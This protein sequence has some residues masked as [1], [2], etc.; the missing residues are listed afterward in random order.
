MPFELSRFATDA[1]ANNP[2]VQ[3]G[4]VGL[5]ALVRSEPF[6]HL[7]NAALD[8]TSLGLPEKTFIKAMTGGDRVTPGGIELSNDQL[9]RL[10]QAYTDQKDPS[11]RPV[12]MEFDPSREEFAGMS[13]EEL[14]R[15][16]QFYNENF[17]KYDN[18]AL[19][20]FNSPYVSTY[21]NTPGTSGY[22]RDL[23]MT[24][25]GLSMTNTPDGM[26][27]QDTWDID[28]ASEVAK[29]TSTGINERDKDRLDL[30]QD[31]KEGGNVPSLIANAARALNT[32]EPIEIDQTVP[33]NTWNSITPR[34]V[35]FEERVAGNQGAALQTLNNLYS[36]LFKRQ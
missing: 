8:R 19:A 31:L 25:G 27:I 12:V 1:I 7:R 14:E 10:K 33:A 11:R 16:R 13:P 28:P 6:Q 24:L 9:A 17:R 29:D 26:R 15:E 3:A 22:G 21:G 35:S 34:E 36:N 4:R 32:Y 20:E 2:V 18:D 23:K 30:V 5:G